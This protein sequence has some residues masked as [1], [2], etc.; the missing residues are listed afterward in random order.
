MRSQAR[1]RKGLQNL[2]KSVESGKVE[3]ESTRQ[4][5]MELV[6]DN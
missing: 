4:R 2:P 6:G 3:K 1:R 5:D